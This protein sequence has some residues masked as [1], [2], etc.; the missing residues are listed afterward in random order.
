M[1]VNL[2]AFF[3][4]LVCGT[5]GQ[6]D[7]WRYGFAAAGVGMVCGLIFYLWGQKFLA[8][9]HLTR[10]KKSHAEKVPLTARE[11]KVIVALMVLVI[12]NAFFWAVYE[13]QGNTLQILAARSAHSPPLG[14]NT[15]PSWSP[16]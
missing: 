8:E 11:W 10:G 5:L 7:G 9:D 2:G 14:F 6:K 4:P 15:P 12:V 3:A 13:Q 1:G 16:S